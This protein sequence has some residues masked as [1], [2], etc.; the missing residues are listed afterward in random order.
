MITIINTVR[1][2]TIGSPGPQGASAQA[3]SVVILSEEATSVTAIIGSYALLSEG[4][5]PYPHVVV[6]TEW[7]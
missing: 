5:T 1:I 4:A 2:A 6:R 7:A 3:A